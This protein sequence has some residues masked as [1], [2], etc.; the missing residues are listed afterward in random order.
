MELP[1]KLG[2]SFVGDESIEFVRSPRSFIEKRRKS[3]GS[4]FQGRVI[5]KPHVFLTSNISVQ[6]LLKG[7][8]VECAFDPPIQS[9]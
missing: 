9:H 4:V 2:Y 1:G 7:R 3:H 8:A 5:N 6:E